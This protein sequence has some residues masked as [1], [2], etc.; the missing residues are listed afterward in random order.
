MVQQR[1]PEWGQDELGVNH[2]RILT[3]V[4]RGAFSQT[5]IGLA[6]GIPPAMGAGKLMIE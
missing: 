2:M 1:Q 6:R 5:G 4:L 3:M